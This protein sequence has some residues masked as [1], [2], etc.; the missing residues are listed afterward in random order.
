MPSTIIPRSEDAVNVTTE[1]LRH[2]MST[3]PFPDSTDPPRSL[4]SF[5]P[6]ELLITLG[7]IGLLAN[8]VAQTVALSDKEMLKKTINVLVVNQTFIDSVACFVLVVTVVLQKTETTGS[9]TAVRQ[10][11]RCLFIDSA[12]VLTTTAYASQAGLVIIT[13]QRYVKLVHPTIHRIY[14]KS[15]MAKVGVAITWLNGIIVWLI[16][17]LVMTKV[18]DGNCQPTPLYG[19]T[20]RTYLT[21]AFIWQ[22]PLPIAIFVFCY[23]RIVSVIRLTVTIAPENNLSSSSNSTTAS[24]Q[25]SSECSVIQLEVT[26]SQRNTIKTIMTIIVFYILCWCPAMLSNLL[27]LYYPSQALIEALR[28]LAIIAF[29]NILIGGVLYGD[30]LHVPDHVRHVIKRSMNLNGLNAE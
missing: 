25:D 22:F 20:G 21:F 4:P 30:H 23:W 29:I 27:Y 12:N 18:V 1:V 10:L 2:A 17:N 16:P 15:W 14:F 26:Q 9:A 19:T 3:P 5:V 24:A 13:L 28:P 11:L 7:I 8:A 6:G